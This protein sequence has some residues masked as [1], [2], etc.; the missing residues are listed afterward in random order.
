MRAHARATARSN[1]SPASGGCAA[2]ANVRVAFEN[3]DDPLG[4]GRA[5]VGAARQGQQGGLADVG[6][7]VVERSGK[8]RGFAE[9]R[10]A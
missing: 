6:M 7:L 1:S 5:D 9:A 8:D 10:I 4:F 3:A 2:H